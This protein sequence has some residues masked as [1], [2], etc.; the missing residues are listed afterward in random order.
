MRLRDVS[1][2]LLTKCVGEDMRRK[3][4][5]DNDSF[6]QKLWFYFYKSSMGGIMNYYHF[7]N[8]IVYICPV[9]YRNELNA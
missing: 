4:L 6:H 9:I 2:H 1:R 3:E 5:L 7:F 8:C